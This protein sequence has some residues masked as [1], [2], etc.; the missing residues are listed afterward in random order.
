MGDAVVTEHP[1]GGWA[2]TIG[3]NRYVVKAPDTE[4]GA[5]VFVV[6]PHRVDG[7]WVGRLRIKLLVGPRDPRPIGAGWS[8]V[9]GPDVLLTGLLPSDTTRL[10]AIQGALLRHL[11]DQGRTR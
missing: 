10:L 2:V 4:G 11:E 3:D 7:E 9:A 5:D 6:G 8:Q 1:D